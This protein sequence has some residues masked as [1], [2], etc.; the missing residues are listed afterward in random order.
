MWGTKWR[1]RDVDDLIAEIKEYKN[2]FGAENFDFFDLTAIVQR[3]WIVEFCEKVIEQKLDISW[4]LPSGTRSEAI[5]FEVAGLMFR[6]GCKNL[7]YAPES[8]SDKVLK[9]IQKRISLEKMIDSVRGSVRAGLN[10]KANMMCGFPE[11]TTLDLLKNLRFISRLSL[12]GCHDLSINQFSPYPGS[13]LFENLSQCGQVT[14]DRK[15]F[16]RLSFYSSMT[17]AYS[18]SE[19]LSS[20]Q[21]LLFKAV[22]TLTFYFLSFLRYPGRVFTT[23]RNVSRGVEFTRLEKTLLSYKRR[24]AG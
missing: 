18:Y 12:A 4:Q 7:S 20:K 22:G 9:I 11:E 1:A 3:K 13:D 15:Y 23:I 14:L 10:V 21:I 8:G 19:H 6:A 16:Q 24:Q 17:N 5:D 2:K